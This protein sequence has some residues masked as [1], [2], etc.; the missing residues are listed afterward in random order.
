MSGQEMCNLTNQEFL[1]KAPGIIKAPNA[2]EN[3]VF[4]DFFSKI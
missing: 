1:D 3:I 2:I 4:S